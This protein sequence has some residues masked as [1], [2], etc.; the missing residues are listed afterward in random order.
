MWKL[1]QGQ[2]PGHATL[3][4]RL[5]IMTL[6]SSVQRE[7]EREFRRVDKSHREKPMLQQETQSFSLSSGGVL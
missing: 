2:S 5:A 4:V 3:T 6:G 7:K 1:L